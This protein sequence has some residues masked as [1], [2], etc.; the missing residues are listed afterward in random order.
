MD[1]LEDIWELVKNHVFEIVAFL[2]AALSIVGSII[3]VNMSL[4]V[5]YTCEP[6]KCDAEPDK[7][8]ADEPVDID[9]KTKV[10]VD[11]KGAVKKPGVYE[12]DAGSKIQDAINKAGGITIYGSTKNINLSK[13]LTDEMVIYVFTKAELEKKEAANEVVCEIPKCECE[14]VTVTECPTLNG[15]TDSNVKDETPTKKPE[16]KKISLNKAT[17]TELQELNGVGEAKAKT[18]IEYREKNGPFEK[19][20]DIQK[21]SGIGSALYEKIKDQ[22]TL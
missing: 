9:E 8:L 12:L 4:D 7:E 16:E 3:Y 6:C 13:K 10:I 18:I 17:V 2:I 19:I 5:D 11:V 21:V 20:E 15:N 14:T 1:Y 22:L